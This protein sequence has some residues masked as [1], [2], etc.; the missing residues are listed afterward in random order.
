MEACGQTTTLTSNIA[1]QRFDLGEIT[2]QL[3]PVAVLGLHSVVAHVHDRISELGVTVAL[4]GDELIATG[5]ARV[6]EGV[7]SLVDVVAYEYSAAWH[8]FRANRYA[9][10]VERIFLLNIGRSKAWLWRCEVRSVALVDVMGSAVRIDSDSVHAIRRVRWNVESSL[11]RGGKGQDSGKSDTSHFE[12]RSVGFVKLRVIKESPSS[13]K[14]H[15]LYMT[16]EQICFNEHFGK[17]HCLAACIII[18]ML[19]I[20]W[21]LR[22]ITL[23]TK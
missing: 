17:I 12:R 20:S 8:T 18:Q 3:A 21:T 11:D 15:V 5:C 23:P 10:L 22:S 16:D 19:D 9:S 14:L 13:G 6:S 2:V 4:S 1:A 7:L